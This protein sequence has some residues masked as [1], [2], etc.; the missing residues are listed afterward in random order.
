VLSELIKIARQ[1]NQVAAQL[2]AQVDSVGHET[3]DMPERFRDWSQTLADTQQQQSE[4]LA[5]LEKTFATVRGE[6]RKELVAITDAL[7]KSE[8]DYRKEVAALVRKIS[9]GHSQEF[10]RLRNEWQKELH[11]I[12][13]AQKQDLEQRHRL[14]VAAMEQGEQRAAAA[15]EEIS[16]LR[17]GIRSEIKEMKL[18]AVRADRYLQE[19]RRESQPAPSKQSVSVASNA[20]PGLAPHEFDYFMFEQRF[21]G[22]M[23]EIKKRQAAY[24]DFFRGKTDVADLGCGRGEFVELLGEHG[25]SAIGVDSNAEMIA[26]CQARGLN[27]VQADLL[28]YL[29]NRTDQSLGG[30]FAAQV[31]E[32]FAANRIMR[33]VELAVRK[34]RPGGLMVAETVNPN[35]PY[36]LGNFY[37]DPTHVKPVP[38][39]L[40]QFM[41]EEAAFEIKEIRFSAPVPKAQGVKPLPASAVMPADYASYQDYAVIA[42]RPA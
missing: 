5:G 40:L 30:I 24:V 15:S 35:C 17:D 29:E 22:D 19:L 39:G 38:F 25:I 6:Q 27:V 7:A 37:L 9:E 33:L 42:A 23:S 13:E 18:R 11:S 10:S 20:A 36:A 21:R 26:S 3:A 32:H 28:E 34:L 12:L 14:L 16:L 1:S 2:R 31:I 41:F 4:M 8:D